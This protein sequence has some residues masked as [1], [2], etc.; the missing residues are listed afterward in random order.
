MAPEQVRGQAADAR[1]DIF[2]LGAVPYVMLSGRRAFAGRTR[3]GTMTAI[4]TKD[5]D[6]LSRPGLSVPASLERIVRRCPRRDGSAGL[7]QPE[8][9]SLGRRG[10]MGCGRLA[11]QEGS[12]RAVRLHFVRDQL[13][14]V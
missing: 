5:P 4:L 3:A 2:A 8:G 12:P 14:A 10:A 11:E 1:S 13:I 6:D 9:Q 7:A